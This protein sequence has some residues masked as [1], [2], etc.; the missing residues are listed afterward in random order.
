MET[1]KAATETEPLPLR[2]RWLP[3]ITA[4]L[5]EKF[6]RKLDDTIKAG[7]PIK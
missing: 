3:K 1:E 2:A 6:P 7:P 4:S 5:A